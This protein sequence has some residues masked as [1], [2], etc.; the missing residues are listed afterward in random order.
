VIVG[1]ALCLTGSARVPLLTRFMTPDDSDGPVRQ[2]KLSLEPLITEYT[3]DTS[4]VMTAI[5]P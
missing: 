3:K 1:L 5:I 4:H 2:A